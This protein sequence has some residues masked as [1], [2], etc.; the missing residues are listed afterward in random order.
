MQK[1]NQH[2]TGF[3]L[4]IELLFVLH[5]TVKQTGNPPAP[6]QRS[7][8]IFRINQSI[9]QSINLKEEEES[10]T[11]KAIIKATPNDG[12][13]TRTT[14]IIL[15]ITVFIVGFYFQ[16]TVFTFLVSA[17]SR[18]SDFSIAES[19]FQLPL[20]RF[21]AGR[22]TANTTSVNARNT[23]DV[24]LT[25]PF[26]WLPLRIFMEDSFNGPGSIAVLSHHHVTV[27][28]DDTKVLC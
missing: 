14:A 18:E 5:P 27:N 4:F 28:V 12:T 26:L 20:L 22:L 9:N 8:A 2:T 6:S 19:S 3:R 16:T 21:W 24:P 1:D 17:T 25:H 23:N 10:D 15:G 13:T 11:M 7:F